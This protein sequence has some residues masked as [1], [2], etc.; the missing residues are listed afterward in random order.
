M[1]D[2]LLC[3]CGMATMLA[4]FKILIPNGKNENLLKYSMGLFLIVSIL[5]TAGKI[6]FSMPEVKAFETAPVGDEL[7]TENL[8]LAIISTLCDFGIEV[9][10]IYFD[11]DITDDGSISITKVTLYIENKEDKEKA[12]EII[13]SQTGLLV[14]AK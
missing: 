5:S 9:T 7:K 3:L 2:L 14:E 6:E 10:E 11:T 8:K 12:V 1:K 4:A 13:K